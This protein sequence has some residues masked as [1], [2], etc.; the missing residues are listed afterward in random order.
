MSYWEAVGEI[1]PSADLP[2]DEFGR[3]DTEGWSAGVRYLLRTAQTRS[4]SL[5][6]GAGLTFFRHSNNVV[7]Q[8][9]DES[10]VAEGDLGLR[11]L[12][13][14]GQ[15]EW[16]WAGSGAWGPFAVAGVEYQQA[17]AAIQIGGVNVEDYEN[18][19]ALGY[20]VGL[21]AE[22]RTTRNPGPLALRAVALVRWLDF[23]TVSWSLP[24]S[25]ELSGPSY[26]V[27][28]GFTWA[29]QRPLF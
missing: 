15:I 23:G 12:I 20:S 19:R 6:L 29:S 10:L 7:I 9:E 21:G 25:P 11:G 16:M 1:L 8:V 3:F 26:Q 27:L 17:D 13:L 2:P 18:A 5:W 14:G 28:L 22:V 4:G 24:D